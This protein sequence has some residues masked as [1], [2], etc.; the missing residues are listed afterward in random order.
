MKYRELLQFEPVEVAVRLGDADQE[1]EARRLVSTFLVSDTMAARLTGQVFPLLH[2]DRAAKAILIAGPRG[3]GKTHLL[4]AISSLAERAELGACVSHRGGLSIAG[5]APAAGAAG[6]DSMA[7]RFRV[8]RATLEPGTAS[9]REI[10]LGHL[11]RFLAGQGVA[12]AFPPAAHLPRHQPP[13]D[14][15]MMAYRRKFPEQGLLLAVDDLLDFLVSRT[16]R[17]L[18]QDLDFLRDLAEAC[19][20]PMFRFIASV[21]ESP[22]DHPRLAGAAAGLHRLHHHCTEVAIGIPDLQF[23]AAARIARKSPEQRAW[24]E[25]HLLRFSGSYDRMRE[26]MGEF[27]DLF[28][29]H[30]DFLPLFARNVFAERRGALR[31]LSDAV[32][33]RLEDDVPDNSPGLIAYDAYWAVMRANPRC[34]QEPEIAAVIDF[35]RML[36]ERL[37]HSANLAANRDMARRIVHALSLRRLTAGDLYSGQG[38]TP[39][40]LRDTLC[41]FQPG[42]DVAAGGPAQSLLDHVKLVLEDLRQSVNGPLITIRAHEGGYHLHFRKFRRFNA[43]ELVLHWANAVPFLLLLVTGGV[44]LG[45]RFS[46]MDRQVLT[47]TVATHKLCAL[48]WLC[49]LPLAVLTRI[50]PHWANIRTLFTWGGADAVWMIQSIRSLY[51]K[52]AVIPPADRFNTGQKINA[53]LVILYFFGFGATGLVMYWKG[54][55]LFP[56]YVHAALFFS[57]LGSVAG[58]LFLALV[59]P[60]TRIALGGIFHGW[61]PMKYV[62]HHHALSLPKSMRAHAKPVSVRTIAEEVLF[63]RVEVGVLIVTILLA[64]AGAYAFGQGRLSTVKKQFAQSFADVIQPS[65]L[66]TKH[67]IGPTAES[68]TKCHLFTGEIPDQKCEECHGDV[69]QRRSE[70]AGFHGSLKGDCR[71]CHREHRERSATLVP[72]DRARFNHDEALFKLAGM[73]A[74]VACDDCHKKTRTADTPGIYYLGLPHERCTDCHRDRHAGQFA[75]SCDTCH[76]PAGWTGTNLLFRH[77]TGSTFPL[78]GRHATVDCRKCHQPANRGDPLGAARFKGLAQECSDCHED[79]HRAQFEDRCAACHTP[80]GWGQKDLLFDHNRDSAFPLADRHAVVDCVKC[81]Q[82]ARAADPLARAQFRGLK[83]ECADCHQDPHRGQFA[84]DCTTCH[85]TPATWTVGAP[86]FEHD[87][88]TPFALLGKHATVRCIQCHQPRDDRATLASA[89]FRGLEASCNNCHTVQHPPSYGTACASCHTP[90]AWPRKQPAFNHARDAGFELMGAHLVAACSACHNADTVGAL[91]HARRPAYTCLT[92]HQR[93]EP[94]KGVLGNDCTKCHDVLGWKGEDLLFDHNTMASFALNADHEN[95][96]CRKCHVDD[97]WKP[98]DS[99][100]ASCHPKLAP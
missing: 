76:A 97:R 29:L 44:M 68:C 98:L 9:L 36:E 66:S 38:V 93:D 51:N 90:E 32:A 13:F 99:A 37:D 24:V 56:W 54:T 87:R 58:H 53:C 6:L 59:N 45:S 91:D 2:L 5:D 4:A 18:D 83:S 11:E 1:G 43:P 77:E 64:G 48:V 14:D 92:C 12:Y 27:V 15:M 23:V 17:G 84:R 26:R 100:C 47:W 35:S 19:R 89:R 69:K 49:A 40:E 41:L 30:P 28:P 63:S 79:P 82:P 65:E 39:A 67:R 52:K 55:I 61:A 22:F 21:Q 10:L 25:S 7:G 33:Q 42:L 70:H 60:S 73:H 88:D 3:V 71:F 20:H 31:I 57:A 75:G 95:V 86:R 46:H 96:E 85:P 78:Q 16:A 50:R 94:H 81:H 74:S 72:L 8:I 34:R 80:G 62:E